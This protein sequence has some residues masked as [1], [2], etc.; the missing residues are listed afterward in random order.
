MENVS[1]IDDGGKTCAWR[2][3]KI[4]R[5][6]IYKSSGANIS[7]SLTPLRLVGHLE[8]PRVNRSLGE[9]K[10][11]GSK[12]PVPRNN[13]RG[14]C[15]NRCVRCGRCERIFRDASLDRLQHISHSPEARQGSCPRPR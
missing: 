14:L 12:I 7:K 5:Q 6:A 2:N 3:V 15:R 11:C 8:S 10:I 4:A 9:A 1:T 13:A